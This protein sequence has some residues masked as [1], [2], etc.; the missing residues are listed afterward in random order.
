[1]HGK[2]VY[3]GYGTP[4][5][6]PLVPKIPI[7]VNTSVSR[8]MALCHKSGYQFEKHVPVWSGVKYREIVNKDLK[9]A[10]RD[11][12]EYV[13]EGKSVI[14][15]QD[16]GPNLEVADSL[17]GLVDEMHIIGSCKEPGLIV[18]A[19][20]DGHKIGFIGRYVIAYQSLQH[21]WQHDK[22]HLH[23][24]GT[25]CMEQNLSNQF[26]ILSIH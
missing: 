22:R 26:Q 21:Y 20:Q 14:T 13:L 5:A 12:R 9:V 3:F 16:W 7:A 24:M 15:T 19:I 1:M 18:D 10:L 6:F 25:G 23:F 2:L 17:K 8:S 4:H 11:Y